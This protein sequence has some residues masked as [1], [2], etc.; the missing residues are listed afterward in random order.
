MNM[1]IT[2]ILV[3]KF[4]FVWAC[5]RSTQNQN[6]EVTLKYIIY[7]VLLISIIL[8]CQTLSSFSYD[9]PC[10]ANI[11]RNCLTNTQYNRKVQGTHGRSDR[12]PQICSLF[13]KW[14]SSL[15][16]PRSS[17]K[18]QYASSSYQGVQ[19]LFLTVITRSAFLDQ[20]ISFYTD[21]VQKLFWPFFHR[22]NML[23]F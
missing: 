14:L 17:V 6:D 1:S 11:K 19:P 16:L 10:H 18:S 3:L 2:A 21:C 9:N 7:S 23:Q 15:P 4:K 20:T 12:G 13:Q 5:I 22:Q 8:M